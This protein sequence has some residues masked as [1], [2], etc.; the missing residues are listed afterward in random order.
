MRLSIRNLNKTY[1]IHQVLRDISLEIEDAR[2][3]A[4]IGPSGSGKS[5]LLRILAG[6]ELPDGAE[7]TS[8]SISW[9]G[10]PMTF[11]EE[12][13]FQYRRNV[14]TVFQSCNLFPH[15]TALQN[16][17]LPLK[18]VHGQSPSAARKEAMDQLA[19]LGLEAHAGKRPGQLSGGQR[20]R[21]AIARA[22]AVRPRV[23]FL[24]E[25]TSA[26]DP[27]MKAEVLGMVE[28]IKNERR[29]LILVTHEMHFA[30]SVADQIVFVAEG[31]I[32]QKGLPQEVMDSPAHDICRNFFA[33][34]LKY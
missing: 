26:L 5:T 10:I 7:R 2:C 21:V 34:V 11:S 13:L 15:I 6:L 23:L 27:E 20:Q 31:Q 24:D 30:R 22:I 16:I 29:D 33:R 19:R 25:P 17:E 14:G 9:D 28:E 3:V 32:L 8:A 18:V 12:A 1:G 4:L